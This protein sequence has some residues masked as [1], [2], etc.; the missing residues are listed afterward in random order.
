MIN[1][2]SFSSVRPSEQLL[3]LHFRH[4]KDFK[5]DLPD[6]EW[7]QKINDFKDEIGDLFSKYELVDLKEEQFL[8]NLKPLESTYYS[9]YITLM[10]KWCGL[11]VVDGWM[12]I[13]N[14]LD[15]FP[16]MAYISRVYVK[17]PKISVGNLTDPYTYMEHLK[18]KPPHQTEAR[19][20]FE[21]D[22]QR[23]TCYIITNN[24]WY[25]LSFD[26]RSVEGYAIAN[27]FN[28][29]LSMYLPIKFPPK[30]WKASKD[31]ILNQRL[32]FEKKKND[33]GF[34]NITEDEKIESCLKYVR[35]TRENKIDEYN[36]LKLG[37]CS[38]FQFTIDKT[39]GEKE[40]EIFQ[41]QTI[42][43]FIRHRY[44]VFSASI[45]NEDAKQAF[46]ES[47]VDRILKEN[48]FCENDADIRFAVLY[49]LLM[50]VAKGTKFTDKLYLSSAVTQ[51]LRKIVAQLKTAEYVKPFIKAL[52]LL[53]LKLDQDRFLD[54]PDAVSK[55]YKEESEKFEKKE[56]S[57]LELN[58][59]M[60]N[61]FMVRRVTITPTRVIYD[62][63]ELN[64]SNRVLRHDKH[65][66]DFFIRVSFRDE[67][68][69]PLHLEKESMEQKNSVS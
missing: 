60:K 7:T 31:D 1:T 28:N 56:V 18:I 4:L 25:K 16:E 67:D 55:L 6:D 52:S 9:D 54:I 57:V 33:R 10:T 32:T 48:E 59:K 34:Y 8:V 61:W 5:D 51:E 50:L 40:M 21:H 69:S 62:P 58:N 38:V 13:V 66:A 15:E 47:V 41:R 27:I 44:T 26:Y 42:A 29:S 53:A 14:P 45:H 30:I 46:N 3:T 39:V 43:G 20:E 24:E 64:T 11:L 49:G 36:T 37:N 35:W 2:V 23:I 19:L 68:F 63:P 65:K 22:M 12:K 17:V